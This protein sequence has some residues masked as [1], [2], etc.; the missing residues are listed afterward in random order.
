MK[1]CLMHALIDLA[2]VSSFGRLHGQNLLGTPCLEIAGSDEIHSCAPMFFRPF[3]FR[4]S[5]AKLCYLFPSWDSF[6]VHS[7]VKDRE[8]HG[9]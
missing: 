6:M 8:W 5:V 2:G 7:E 1:T 3:G 9:S 4:G